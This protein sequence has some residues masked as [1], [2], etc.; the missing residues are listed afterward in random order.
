MIVKG[1]KLDQLYTVVKDRFSSVL[2]IEDSQKEN[3]VCC[4]KAEDL[5]RLMFLI[6]EKVIS[7]K[8]EE[9]AKLLTWVSDS[10]T[11]KEIDEFFH[12]S[13]RI[14]RN[15]QVLKNKLK[16][17]EERFYRNRSGTESLIF[18]RTMN[19]LECVLVKKNL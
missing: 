4:K 16:A 6:K 10:W 12:V 13:N 1:T 7:A 8:T 17:E 5:N 9:K 15:R 19:P 18:T 2:N 11:L 14:A 3:V